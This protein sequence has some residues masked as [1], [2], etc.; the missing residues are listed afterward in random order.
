MT[1]VTAEPYIGLLG[2]GGIGDTK[3]ELESEM[4]QRHIKW[5]VNAKVDKRRFQSAC[6]GP[7]I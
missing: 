6:P 1:F 7:A 3:G 2:V 4:R 5:I